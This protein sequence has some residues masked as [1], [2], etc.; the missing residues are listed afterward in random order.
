MRTAISVIFVFCSFGTARGVGGGH[1]GFAAARAASI[2]A[3]NADP[4][5]REGDGLGSTVTARSLVSSLASHF[6][7]TMAV[8]RRPDR[9][10][11]H[12]GLSFLFV[13]S[14]RPAPPLVCRFPLGFLREALQ[15]ASNF[16]TEVNSTESSAVDEFLAQVRFENGSRPAALEW[17]CPER[18]VCCGTDCCPLDY[19]AVWKGIIFFA[20]LLCVL[21][22]AIACIKKHAIAAK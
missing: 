15:L 7:S 9:P 17:S 12:D 5:I 3:F 4:T 21:L 6:Y 2:A 8:I 18:C 20:A 1:D 11:V 13:H 16:S 10:L 19:P 22:V 14:S